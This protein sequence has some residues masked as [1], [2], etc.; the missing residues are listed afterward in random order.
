MAMLRAWV[1][2]PEAQRWWGEPSEQL[3]LIVEDLGNDAMRQWIVSFEGQPFAYAQAYEVHAWPQ[4]HLAGLPP[5]TMAV[6]AFIG[7]SGMIGLGHGSRFL[8]RLAETLL[9]KGAPL[10]VIDPAVEN[11]RAQKAYRKAGFHEQTRTETE[12]GPVVL[13]TFSGG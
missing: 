9:A 10:I 12:T 6:D 5:G 13:M 2:T 7:I 11:S 3:A 4:P 8:R 1:A